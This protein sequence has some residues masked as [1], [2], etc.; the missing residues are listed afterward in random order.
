MPVAFG[1]YLPEVWAHDSQR[2]EKAG[3]PA[4]I[5]FRT[6]PE[7]ALGQIR[8]AHDR[9]IPEGVV[10]ADAGYGTDTGFRTELTKRGEVAP[11][12]LPADLILSYWHFS[13]ITKVMSSVCG[14]P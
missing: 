8:R 1:L 6:K 2:R 14:V 4:E 3:V 11:L 10:L 7:I 12:W 9:G 13:T 5:P